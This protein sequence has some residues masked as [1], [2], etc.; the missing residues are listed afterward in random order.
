MRARWP[1]DRTGSGS[2]GPGPSSFQPVCEL[3]DDA[4][5]RQAVGLAPS[6]YED[7]PVPAG[8]VEAGQQLGPDGVTQTPFDEIALHR[9]VPVTGHDQAYPG[10]GSGGI[11]IENV[12]MGRSAPFPP[13]EQRP[14]FGAPRDPACA[15]VPT[16][17]RARARHPPAAGY[18]EPTRTERRFRPR[19]RRRLSAL[20]PPRVFI[21]LRKPCLFLR[22]RFRGLYVGLP[23]RAPRSVVVIHKDLEY[24]NSRSGGQGVEGRFARSFGHFRPVDGRGSGPLAW[25]VGT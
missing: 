8:P 2:G 21:R 15:R 23:M 19:L 9:R 13:L 12:Q 14:D 4:D 18:F 5:V 25:A 10:K 16:A 22:L 17:A 11:G 24:R 6:A 3:V 1:G 7:V 20:R